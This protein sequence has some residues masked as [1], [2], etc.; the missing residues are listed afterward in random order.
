MA[1]LGAPLPFRLGK[2]RRI[3]HAALMTELPTS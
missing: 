2:N 1:E 3:A